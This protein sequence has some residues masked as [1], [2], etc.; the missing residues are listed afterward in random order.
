MWLRQ[1]RE[2]G[3]QETEGGLRSFA[4]GGRVGRVG[5]GSEISLEG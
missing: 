5:S 2:R 3:R 4:G 1:G